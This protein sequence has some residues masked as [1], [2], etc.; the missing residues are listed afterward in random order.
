MS[1]LK[2]SRG[3]K[4]ILLTIVMMFAMTIL[5][6]CGAPAATKSLTDLENGSFWQSNVV[7]WFAKALDTFANWFG[8]QYGLA[9]LVMVIIVRTLILPLTIKQVKSSKAMQAIQ[10]E[11][12]K[13]KEKFKDNPE[14]QQKET[15]RLFQENKVNPLAG[16]LPL[17]VQMPIFIALYN[18]IYGNDLLRHGTFL[19]LQ[20]GSPDK[21]F[22]LPI[23]AALTT[24]LQTKM[25][26]KMNPTPQAG[27][28]QFM[29]MVYPVLIFF[30]SY[31]FPAALPLYW[32]FSNVYTI[33]QNYFLYRTNDKTA[34]VSGVALAGNTNGAKKGNKGKGKNSKG[35]KRSK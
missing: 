33:V 24:F 23:L 18:S 16:C 11:L 25:M 13:L 17:I 3:K 32:F 31:N 12:A 15:M 26:M 34:V 9:V 30:M 4:W 5:S 28:M 22:I 20:L 1:R 8:G 27:P 7:Y 2:T 6:G 35:A 19:W 29:M 14:E 21:T 10:P